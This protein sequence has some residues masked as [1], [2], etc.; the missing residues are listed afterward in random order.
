MHLREINSDPN[1]LR[2]KVRSI[3]DG[4][5]VDPSDPSSGANAYI[6]TAASHREWKIREQQPS[7]RS[8]SQTLHGDVAR[9][10]SMHLKL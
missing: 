9:F 7:M 8:S 6:S 5:L 4:D 1:Y 10:A 3:V 2:L